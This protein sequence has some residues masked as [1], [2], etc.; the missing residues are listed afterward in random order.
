MGERKLLQ[1]FAAIVWARP[2]AWSLDQPLDPAAKAR[3]THEQREAVLA[4]VTEYHPGVPLVFGV[5]FGH[6]EPQHVIPSGGEVTVDGEAR[7]LHVT[8]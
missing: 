3:F 8:Y 1:R 7:E 2:R 6:T 4:A 5:D